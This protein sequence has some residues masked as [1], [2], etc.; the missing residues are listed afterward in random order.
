MKINSIKT[1]LIRRT[2]PQDK[3]CVLSVIDKLMKDIQAGK[4]KHSLQ[5]ACTWYN[6]FDNASKEGFD[7]YC[8]K[9]PNWIMREI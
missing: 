2:W 4:I 1:D 3:D 6:H 8:V 7:W 9:C 5:A